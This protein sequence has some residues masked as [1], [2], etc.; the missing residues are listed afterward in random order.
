[1]ESL[2]VG[3]PG[4]EMIKRGGFG[5]AGQKGKDLGGGDPMGEIELSGKSEEGS[6]HHSEKRERGEAQ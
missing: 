5:V 2:G 6:G 3:L 1:L 4:T